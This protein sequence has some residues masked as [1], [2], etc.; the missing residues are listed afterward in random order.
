MDL[1]ATLTECAIDA[2]REAVP[3]G[4]SMVWLFPAEGDAISI[5]FPAV[6][7]WRLDQW[8]AY[9]ED[10]LATYVRQVLLQPDAAPTPVAHLTAASAYYTPVPTRLAVLLPWRAGRV[11][12]AVGETGDA[13]RVAYTPNPANVRVGQQAIR[14]EVS[15]AAY[16]LRCAQRADPLSGTPQAFLN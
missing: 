10:R 15:L 5:V 9:I 6:K 12:E 11:L 16:L 13:I 8:L 14:R 3:A 4:A 2:A 1:A 7:R